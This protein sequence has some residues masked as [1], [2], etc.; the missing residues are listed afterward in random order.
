VIAL[1]EGPSSED[2]IKL[3]ERD[4][5][6][7]GSI[8]QDVEE[9]V[10][11]FKEEVV[12]IVG[13]PRQ[14]PVDC[15]RVDTVLDD[16]NSAFSDMIP[17]KDT[18]NDTLYQ[19]SSK[20]FVGSDVIF[21][22]VMESDVR[23]FY[24][25]LELSLRQQ[26]QTLWDEHYKEVYDILNQFAHES[27]DHAQPLLAQIEQLKKENQLLLQQCEVWYKERAQIPRLTTAFETLYSKVSEL[28]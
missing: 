4:P 15:P 27:R 18:L 8:I 3:E 25:N 21:K 2:T 16:S 28:E 11:E 20:C 23:A 13:R 24:E 6:L 7:S 14:P 9:G 12:P 17:K 19:G 26:V 5:S 1:L 10:K 22:A